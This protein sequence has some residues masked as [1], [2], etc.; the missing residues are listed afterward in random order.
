MAQKEGFSHLAVPE[1]PFG[2]TRALRFFDRCGTSAR[3]FSA[4]G[5]GRALVPSRAPRA[6]N[7]NSTF[8]YAKKEPPFWVVLFWRRRR[9]LR[10]FLFALWG[11]AKRN[12]GIDQ[13]LNWSMKATCVA[14]GHDSNPSS[15][16]KRD[17]PKVVSF[18]G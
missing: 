17:Y 18:Y 6:R 10:A 2:L 1:K 12:Q 13:F 3:P 14:F 7:H 5:S 16:I 4:T 9:D 11:T 8:F 15:G